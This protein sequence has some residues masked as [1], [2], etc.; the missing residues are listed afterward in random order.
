[1]PLDEYDFL[2][3]QS[4]LRHVNACGSP[5]RVRTTSLRRSTSSRG[6]L[7][8]GASSSSRLSGMSLMRMGSRA[9]RSRPQ[10]ISKNVPYACC[11]TL[12][13]THPAKCNPA[14]SYLASYAGFNSSARLGIARTCARLTL[15]RGV[16]GVSGHRD[17]CGGGAQERADGKFAGSLRLVGSVC[18]SVRIG[19]SWGCIIQAFLLRGS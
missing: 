18:G 1:M 5:L 19:I 17:A 9:R 6:D 8:V 10:S 4:H 12:N 15:M 16:R 11:S 13:L 14:Q 3:I 2:T 7:Q